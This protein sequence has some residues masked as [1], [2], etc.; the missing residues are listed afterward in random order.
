M[1]LYELLPIRDPIHLTPD[2]I[3]LA[4]TKLIG[5]VLCKANSPARRFD[6]CHRFDRRACELEPHGY[7]LVSP[8]SDYRV[9]ALVDVRDRGDGILH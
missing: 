1:A 7:A 8:I 9:K 5:D 6:A 4:I 3:N 2:P